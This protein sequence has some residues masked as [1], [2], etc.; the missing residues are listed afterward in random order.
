MRYNNTVKLTLFFGVLAMGLAG[1]LLTGIYPAGKTPLFLCGFTLSFV[2]M[3][4]LRRYWPHDWGCVHIM[5]VAVVAR[6]FLIPL[7]ASDD[8]NR[9]LWE[10]KCP[11]HNINPYK[12]APL[13]PG[14]TP[15]RD[16]IW[17]GINHKEFTSIYGPLA[18]HV[19]TAAAFCWY[20]PYMLKLFLTVCDLG[21]L[22]LLL[23]F[24]KKRK[25]R[26]NEALLYAINPLVLFSFAGEGHIDCLMLFMLAA[27]ML[28][29]QRKHFVWL[30]IFLGCACSVKLTAALFIPFF[31]R[32]DTLR[33][34]PFVF[35]PAVLALRYGTGIISLVT[36][37]ARYGTEFHF[38]GCMY[39]LCATVF[40]DQITLLLCISLFIVI[41]VWNLFLTPDP[42]KAAGNAAMAF[43]LTSPTAQP[44]YF[45]LIA[46]FA[47]LYPA[48][49]W[50]ALT[51]TA[52]LSWLP[53][54]AYWAT[55]I[56]KEFVYF[57]AL[58]YAPPAFLEIIDRW[59]GA[60]FSSPGY[61]APK[62]VSVII[63]VLNE[64]QRLSACLKSICVPPNLHAEIIVV[65][66]GSTDDTPRIARADERVKLVVSEK[67]RGIQVSDGVLRASGDLIIIVHADTRLVPDGVERI[68]RF[69][70]RHHHIIGGSVATRFSSPGFRY[71]VITALNNFRSRFSGIS[72]GD[73]VQFFRRHTLLDVLPRVK[74]MEDIE[75]SLLLKERGPVAVLPFLA[76]SSA[77]RWEKMAYISNMITVISLTVIYIVR[78]RCGFL[79]GDNSDFYHNYYG[80]GK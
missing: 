2:G 11:L 74:L 14:T 42:V 80:V 16:A 20:S 55:G 40:S 53:I 60:G 65:D 56:W 5:I 59:Q 1:F 8:L 45:T 58:E 50:I 66:G 29:Y 15:L 70:T 79:K 28:M 44:W 18:Q 77:R 23:G 27:S 33:Y 21:T 13:D 75:I 61:G 10:G 22:L 30:F 54:F 57:L 76:R 36:V 52:S 72:F 6:C 34:V 19:F 37:T 31:I 49:S 24:L 63:P 67:G 32:K 39:G 68:Y 26:P 25:S 43:L 17:Q 9:Y 3:L 62:S 47:V 69:C 71:A 4:G 38:N 41:Y 12:T 78:R 51:G 73:Q 7:P 48:R 35:V 46:L 64:G